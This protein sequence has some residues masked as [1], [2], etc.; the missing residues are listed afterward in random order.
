MFYRSFGNVKQHN[1]I[2]TAKFD[3]LTLVCFQKFLIQN[4]KSI[5]SFLEKFIKYSKNVFLKT[6]QQ[7]YYPV[8]A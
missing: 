7:I 8:F 3:T 6:F 5:K 1:E 4:M 2:G